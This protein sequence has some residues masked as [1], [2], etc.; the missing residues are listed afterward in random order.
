MLVRLKSAPRMVR[1]ITAAF[2]A[3]AAS[4]VA[5]ESS[6]AAA[7]TQEGVCTPSSSQAGDI[8][9]SLNGVCVS[10]HD[11]GAPQCKCDAPW[12]GSA[13]GVMAYAKTTPASGRS[14][15]PESDARNSW[16]GAIMRGADGVYHC[17]NPIYPVGELGGAT[18]LMHGTSDKVTGPYA[19]PKAAAIPI[20]TLGSFDGPKSVVYTDENNVTKYSLWFGGF[21]YLAD[22][23]AGPWQVIPDFHYPGHNPAPVFHD[24]AFYTIVSMTT[25]I[26]TTPKLE[27]G[28]KWAVFTSRINATNVPTGWIPEDPDMWVDKRGNWHIVNHA[29]NPHEWEHCG[30]SVLSSHFFSRDGKTWDFLP[31]AI[32]P[33]SHT[34]SYD[35]GSSHMFVTMERPNLFFDQHGVL[36]HIHLAADLVTGEEGCGNRTDHAH[37]GHTPCDNC[38]VS[39]VWRAHVH[40]KSVARSLSLLLL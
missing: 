27:S 12:S 11:D 32:E 5:A 34:V 19:W 7:A 26:M 20:P 37:F 13:C 4:G 14:L 9:C 21:V 16:N 24:G 22:D 39:V 29:Y 8:D 3:A 38:K 36:T 23:A 10:G 17:Y 6:L 31:E 15:F 40:S 30:T 35:D 18:T 28:A 1:L 33:Y 25:G 2:V